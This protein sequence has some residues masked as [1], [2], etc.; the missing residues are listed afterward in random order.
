MKFGGTNAWDAWRFHHLATEKAH[1][2]LRGAGQ[3]LEMQLV[4]ALNPKDVVSLKE[5]RP[6][7]RQLK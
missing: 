4:Q 5:R 1:L 2:K 6:A 7:E 3:I